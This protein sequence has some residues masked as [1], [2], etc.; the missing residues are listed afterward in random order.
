MALEILWRDG[1]DHYNNATD[2][3]TLYAQTSGLS[4]F[5]PGRTNGKAF[6][7]SNEGFTSGFTFNAFGSQSDVTFAFAYMPEGT[8]QSMLFSALDLVSGDTLA[9]F[10]FTVANV[11]V[12]TTNAGVDTH[13]IPII[14]LANWTHIQL[15]LQI[16]VGGGYEVIFNGS[17]IVAQRSGINT[18]K[19]T[20]TTVN[21]FFWNSDG[22][23][24]NLDDFTIVTG[25]FI[26]D[27][28]IQTDFPSIDH[29][30]AFTPLTGTS[31]F[32]MV[33]ETAMDSDATYNF[34]STVGAT[35]LFGFPAL[36]LPAGSSILDVSLV[37]AARKDDAGNRSFQHQYLS[38]S[39][40]SF[41]TPTAISTSYQYFIDAF[42]NDPATGLPWTLAALNA[43]FAGYL[44]QA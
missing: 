6:T 16:G 33:D 11:L 14:P 37:S 40:S 28:R 44:E 4:S 2:L 26:G 18:T 31:H 39:T 12:V 9:L 7:T 21:S 15:R 1:F 5:G 22:R 32:A 23:A 43:A 19:G 36:V 35:D 25:G 13:T 29:S 41:G 10:D 42:P 3:N 30:V 17:T 38:G 27:C 8:T 20:V 34:T 24:G